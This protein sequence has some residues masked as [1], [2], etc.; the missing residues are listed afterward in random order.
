MWFGELTKNP[1]KELQQKDVG[2]SSNAR[3]GEQYL[4]EFS[5]FQGFSGFVI[6]VVVVLESHY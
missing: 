4:H 1:V 2:R 5:Q 6:I 3:N